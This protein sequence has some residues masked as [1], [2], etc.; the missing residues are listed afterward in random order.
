MNCMNAPEKVGYESQLGK[1]TAKRAR[2][3]KGG[4]AGAGPGLEELLLDPDAWHALVTLAVLQRTVI[5][6][7]PSP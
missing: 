1:L 6:P 5:K 7:T 4:L 3:A 2:A